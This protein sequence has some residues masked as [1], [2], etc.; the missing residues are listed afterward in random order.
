MSHGRGD[1][2]S[3]GFDMYMRLLDQ[4][5]AVLSDEEPEDRPDVYLELEYSGFIPDSYI[6]EPVEKMEVY[7]KI[8]SITAEEELEGVFAEVQDRFGPLPDAV[9]SLLA[10]AEIRI[11]CRKLRIGSLRE[12]GGEVEVEFSRVADISVD[13]AVR[14]AAQAFLTP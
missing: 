11:L 2:L 6:A 5:I 14:L 8:A 7:K 4:A 1:I 12:R 3:V 13:K 10:L 9:Q